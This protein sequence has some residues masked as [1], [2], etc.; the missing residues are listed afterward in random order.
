VERG[1]GK[2]VILSAAKDLLF[3]GFRF[4]FF[5]G[6]RAFSRSN[7]FQQDSAGTDGTKENAKTRENAR[8]LTNGLRVRRRFVAP[9]IERCEQGLELNR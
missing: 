7:G 2:A 8:K 3:P 6:I 4:A 1:T 9:A 5:R